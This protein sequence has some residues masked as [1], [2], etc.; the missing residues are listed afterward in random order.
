MAEPPELAT[1]MIGKLH[2]VLELLV[3]QI[4]PLICEEKMR[5]ELLYRAARRG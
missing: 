4:V 1:D 5:L 2:R 3:G